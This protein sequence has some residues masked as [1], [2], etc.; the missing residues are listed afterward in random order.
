MTSK[1][2]GMVIVALVAVWSVAGLNWFAPATSYAPRAPL[3]VSVAAA[4]FT[5]ALPT[6]TT[7]TL[8]GDPDQY[9]NG[10]Q[11]DPDQYAGTAPP[12]TTQ[13]SSGTGDSSGSSGSRSLLKT[14]TQIVTGVLSGFRF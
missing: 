4:E 14:V 13:N 8:D 10:A 12:D 2:L 7:T 11:G 1:R 5:N 9:A 6:Y 3:S